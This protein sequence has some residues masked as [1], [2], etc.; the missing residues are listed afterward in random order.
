MLGNLTEKEGQ[1][2]YVLPKLYLAKIREIK[3]F[4]LSSVP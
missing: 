3:L 1:I 4:E 2:V